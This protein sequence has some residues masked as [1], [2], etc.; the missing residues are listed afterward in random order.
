LGTSFADRAYALTTGPDGSIYVSGNTGG[1]LGGQANI[2]RADAFITKYL[3]DG[4][5][6]WTKLL[7]SS[8]DSRGDVAYA[9]TTGSDGSIYVSGTTSGSL[10]GQPFS[11]GY[12][13]AFITKYKTDGTK[14]WTRLMDT[15]GFNDSATALTSGL[16]GS[17]YVS[18]HHTVVN[19]IGQIVNGA[20]D[21][22]FSKFNTDGTKE[23]TR[24]LGTSSTDRATALTT[25]SD[26]WIYVSGF[27]SGSIDGE[28]RIGGNDAFISRYN[29]DGI[30]DWTRLLGSSYSD[31]AT[32]LT[33]GLDGSIYVSGYT[34]S[35]IDGQTYSGGFADA[36]ISKYNPYGSKEW[37]L[38]GY[39]RW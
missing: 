11:G 19:G 27:S 25:G 20:D 37:T 38:I 4:T 17:I 1:N 10:D 31:S 33:T 32:A 39:G 3:P 14:E 21:I 22:F 5:K 8:A 12:G 34:S 30:K 7:G 18:G 35:S 13:D 9:L 2:G 36:F 24:Q 16:D 15:V 26:G 28:T 23:W 6:S 29:T